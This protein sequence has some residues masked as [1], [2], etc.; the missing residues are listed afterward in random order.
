MKK[1]GGMHLDFLLAIVRCMMMV[2]F[3]VLKIGNMLKKKIWM[4]L[5]IKILSFLPMDPM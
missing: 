1:D 4:V 5:N 2:I 3:I